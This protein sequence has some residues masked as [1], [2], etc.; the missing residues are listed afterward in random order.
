MLN[1]LRTLCPKQRPVLFVMAFMALISCKEDE[2]P[3]FNL[4]A[5]DVFLF[6]QEEV[7]EFAA[8]KVTYLRG[9]LTIF[10]ED[11]SDLRGFSILS[12]IE[13]SLTI[14]NTQVRNVDAFSNLMRLDGPLEISNNQNLEN[15]N[16]F[17][18]VGSLSGELMALEIHSN[19]K[20]TTIDQFNEF[21]L[22]EG[23]IN[24]WDNASL[25]EVD[26]QALTEVEALSIGLNPQLSD[27]SGF[28]QLRRVK[29]FSVGY[30]AVITTLSDFNLEHVGVLE[31]SGLS[32]LPNLNGL[33]SIR[34]VEGIIV[35][36]N[37]LITEIDQF[38]E[39]TELTGELYLSENSS[40]T[41]V[42]FGKLNYVGSLR[43]SQ[44]QLQDFS[45]FPELRVI[46]G[47]LGLFSNDRLN[48]LEDL[49]V[50]EIRGE[51]SLQGN[52]QITSLAPLARLELIGGLNIQRTALTNLIG[53]ENATVLSGIS[54]SDNL[55]LESLEGLQN[56][57]QVES[58]VFL[59]N[60]P[61]L[62][63]LEGL[64]GLE[65]LGNSLSI[66]DCTNL[67]DFCA[68]EQLVSDGVKNFATIER[69]AYNPTLGDIVRG[70]CRE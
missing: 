51:L 38:R 4:L 15:L 62:T 30:S 58:N 49:T 45:G 32:N 19:P 11:I 60:S 52:A 2:E 5:E 50:N 17:R 13:G 68:L 14:G 37:D 24:I 8:R 34:E 28:S 53:L 63:N 36:N 23:S 67:T 40:L 46:G 26:F 35:R 22:I 55:Q 31:I 47:S 6:S 59:K 20:L 65:T 16:G 41:S 7:N 43:L 44:T 9:N 18:Q 39:F 25:T 57:S 27:L 12:G 61:L 29:Y 21:E 66:Y 69:N 10:G 48:D 56:V 64:N 54:I 70:D 1:L 3:P 33:E 42:D